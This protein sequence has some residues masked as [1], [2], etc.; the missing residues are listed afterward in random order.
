[1][2]PV[3]KWLVFSLITLVVL[4]IGGFVYFK[5]NPAHSPFFPKCPFLMATGL[6]CPGCGSQRTLHAL[7]HGDLRSAFAH[8]TLLVVSI[9]YLLLLVFAHTLQVF[10]PATARF[11]FQIQRPEVIQLYLALVVL[12]WIG[13]NLFHF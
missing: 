2:S 12:F 9:P 8:N 4:L 5:F 7:L 11:N 3:K 13:R 1:M 10:I 6:K